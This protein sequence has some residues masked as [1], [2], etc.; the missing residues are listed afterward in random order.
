MLIIASQFCV[1]LKRLFIVHALSLSS[2]CDS[3]TRYGFRRRLVCGA[4][5]T[6]RSK[7]RS[8]LWSWYAKKSCYILASGAVHRSFHL[9]SYSALANFIQIYIAETWEQLICYIIVRAPFFSCQDMTHCL[10][11]SLACTCSVS[12]LI[13]TSLKC[14]CNMIERLLA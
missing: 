7:F 10:H 14:Y 13:E 6:L 4:S 2:T 3:F 9:F 5:F 11:C 8:V 12:S 1:M